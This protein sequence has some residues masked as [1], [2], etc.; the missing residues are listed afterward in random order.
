MVCCLQDDP[1]VV[2][3]PRL[4]NRQLARRLQKRETLS[5][6]MRSLMMQACELAETV[7]NDDFDEPNILCLDSIGE[8]FC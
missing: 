6:V 3:N 1:E 4:R 7:L 2:P 5:D 8:C